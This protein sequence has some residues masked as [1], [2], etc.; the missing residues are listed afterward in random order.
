[1]QIFQTALNL[2]SRLFGRGGRNLIQEHSPRLQAYLS[3]KKLYDGLSVRR[4]PTTQAYE[5]KV[6][7]V[8][9]ARTVVEIGADFLA[10]SPVTFT[11]SKEE[12]GGKEI[13][14]EALTK[15][16]NEIWE[17]SGGEAKFLPQAIDGGIKGDACV[18]LVKGKDERVRLRWVDPSIAFP[19]FDAHD[20][21]RLLE[22]IIGYE[23]RKEDGSK[24]EY[25]QRW[26]PGKVVTEIDDR[27]TGEQVTFNP[28][29]CDG[30]IPAVWIRNLGLPGEKFGRSD[31]AF[32]KE[33]VERY[34]HANS[35]D[36]D[37]VD[38]YSSPHLKFKGVKKSDVEQGKIGNKT[39]FYF[40]DGGDVD[41]LEWAGNAPAVKDSLDRMRQDLSEMAQVPSI[42]F[43]RL[44]EG[45]KGGDVSGVA[46]RIMYA[47]LL[48]KTRRKRASW[49]PALER[50]MAFAVSFEV[51]AVVEVEKV[52]INW[53]DPLP[54]NVKED[55]ETA[56]L[57]KEAGVSENQV[58]RERGYDD[59]QITQMEEEKTQ[60]AERTAM[61]E[62]KA[63]DMGGGLGSGGSG[64]SKE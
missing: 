51:G 7:A 28:E 47:P 24:G 55:W 63:F 6:L 56:G 14:D 40:K 35:K 16:A 53:Q 1:M 59:D 12:E 29:L 18:V 20:C 32:L 33:L 58:L 8:D 36:L 61:A 3:C 25:I 30:G 17:R 2:F 41:F 42:A 23:V 22:L 43:G 48:A 50:V 19:E 64:K 34:D 13:P 5:E 57:Q 46:L 31:I 38:Y 9:H 60:E 15:I 49:G 11:I 54:T 62:A 26:T 39:A 52:N 27:E 45:V 37:I 4:N 10:G 44:D 21:D